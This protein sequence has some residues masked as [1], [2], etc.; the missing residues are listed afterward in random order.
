V[1]VQGECDS[2]DCFVECRGAADLAQ[3]ICKQDAS[4]KEPLAF[5]GD[6]LFGVNSHEHG[7]QHLKPHHTRKCACKTS[8]IDRRPTARTLL[9]FRSQPGHSAEKPR[10]EAHPIPRPQLCLP[11][12]CEHAQR[13]ITTQLT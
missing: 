12:R 10:E 13:D 1:R 8:E 9:I 3:R 4:D 7:S 11:T 5:K 2:F 6:V